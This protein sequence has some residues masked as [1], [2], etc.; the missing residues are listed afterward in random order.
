[1]DHVPSCGHASQK[2]FQVLGVSR[3]TITAFIEVLYLCTATLTALFGADK[4]NRSDKS[5]SAKR[6][7]RVGGGRMVSF[8]SRHRVLLDLRRVSMFLFTSPRCMT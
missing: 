1:M 4:T 6:H 5:F 8:L 7:H 3:S 2:R